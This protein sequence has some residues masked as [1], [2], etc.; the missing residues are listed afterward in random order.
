M[1][2]FLNSQASILIPISSEAAHPHRKTFYDFNQHMLKR[3][4]F[5]VQMHK[6]G[7]VI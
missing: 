7:F 1:V 4:L 2:T 5:C 6:I 3:F